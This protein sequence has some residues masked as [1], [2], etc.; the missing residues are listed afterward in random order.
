MT[1]LRIATAMMHR[2]QRK[3]PGQIEVLSAAFKR[4]PVK[5]TI[6]ECIEL[7]E[8]VGLERDQVSK[9]NWD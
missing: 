8:R 6:E 5:W 1:D 2:R 3:K 4:N 9:W 7:G